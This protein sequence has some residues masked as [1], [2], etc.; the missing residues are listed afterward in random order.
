MKVSRWSRRDVM[1]A[2]SLA[3]VAELVRC[4]SAAAQLPKPQPLN[5]S[6]VTFVTTTEAKPWQTATVFK[7]TFNWTILNLNL[8]G[9]IPDTQDPRSTWGWAQNSLVTVDTAAKTHRYDHD[10][11]FLK[12]LTHFVDVGAKRLEATGTCDDALAFRNPDGNLVAVLRNESGNPQLV[13]VQAPGGA[14]A[15]ELPPDS[16]GTLALKPA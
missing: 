3:A 14:V 7:P 4:R 6:N 9:P 11:Y 2:G 5:D 10:Y 13:Q 8:G 15:V 16:I 1:R 12:H